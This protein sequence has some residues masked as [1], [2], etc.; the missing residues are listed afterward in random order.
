MASLFYFYDMYKCVL[1]TG[2]L[3]L[4][5]RLSASV[6]MPDIPWQLFVNGGRT[7]FDSVL[8][9]D[10]EFVRHEVKMMFDND[11]LSHPYTKAYDLKADFEVYWKIFG[12]YWRRCDLNKDDRFE[13]FFNGVVNME[14][15]MEVFQI[16]VLKDIDY[17]TVYDRPGRLIAYKIHPLTGEVILFHHQY[18][19]CN[20]ASHNINTVRL[21]DGKAN[22]RKKYFVAR[23]SEMKGRFFPKTVLYEDDYSILERKTMLRWSG[24]VIRYGAW[25]RSPSNEIVHYAAG[26]PYRVLAIEEGWKYVLMC[27]PPEKERSKVIN[28]D[29]FEDVKVY[30]WIRE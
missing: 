6:V 4:V 18:P 26:T 10:D 29:N 13:L 30:G 28:P 9:A 25:M 27:G 5:M 3:L 14:D 20:N 21:I 17:E 12:K 1:L 11:Q 15:S 16:Y 8:V 23:D 24:E 7:D 19:C 22:L 2:F